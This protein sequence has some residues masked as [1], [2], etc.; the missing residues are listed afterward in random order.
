[1]K[2]EQLEA[3]SYDSDEELPMN[4]FEIGNTIDCIYPLRP[5]YA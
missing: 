3:V 1:M 2:N 4:A 5:I